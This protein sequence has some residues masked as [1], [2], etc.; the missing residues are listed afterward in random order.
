[1]SRHVDSTMKWTP[2]VDG[3]ILT[4]LMEHLQPTAPQMAQATEALR[5]KGYNVSQNALRY[6]I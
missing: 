6:S 4:I 1:M 5:A 3:I 2:E